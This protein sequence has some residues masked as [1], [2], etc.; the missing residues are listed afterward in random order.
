MAIEGRLILLHKPSGETSYLGFY[1][2]Y[3]G[4]YPQPYVEDGIADIMNAAAEHGN[5]HPPTADDFELIYE[6]A[7]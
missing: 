7:D 4:W 6:K 3:E 2:S 1:Q 5:D